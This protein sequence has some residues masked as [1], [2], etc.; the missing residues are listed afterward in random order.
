MHPAGRRRSNR[1]SKALSIILSGSDIEG[2]QV[3]EQ[4]KTLVLSRH[5]AGIV[6]IHKLNPEE[7]LF[8]RCLE[9]NKEAAVRVVGQVGRMSES[10]IYGVAFLH[11]NVDLWDVEFAPQIE[12]DGEAESML[13]ECTSC[14]N[15]EAINPNDIELDVYAISQTI[16]RH[17]KKCGRSTPW[18]ESGGDADANPSPTETQ[19]GPQHEVGPIPAGPRENRRKDVRAKVNFSACIRHS[20]SEEIVVCENVSRGGFCF[21]SPKRYAEKSNIEVALPYSP[22]AP[23]IF[24]RAQIVHVHELERDKLFRCGAAYVKS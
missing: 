20:G 1:I 15:R 9:T 10:Y 16:S 19:K 6:S 23:G 8:I 18:R 2:K 17:C 22:G 14:H 7:V 4:T 21:R 3:S 13:L 12:A 5:G 11:S 24:V